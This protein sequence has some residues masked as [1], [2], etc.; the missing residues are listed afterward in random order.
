VS[1]FLHV[2]QISALGT[3]GSP[4]YGHFVDIDYP[5]LIIVSP[6]GKR[7]LAGKSVSIG[8]AG[9]AIFGL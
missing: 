4:Q 1:L 9:M 6:A 7:R 3:Q 8:R 5:Q 2:L